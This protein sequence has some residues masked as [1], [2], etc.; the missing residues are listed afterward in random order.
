MDIAQDFDQRLERLTKTGSVETIGR[1]RQNVQPILG[2]RRRFRG[3]DRLELSAKRIQRLACIGQ[4]FR[5][6][7][8]RFL[9]I[10][11]RRGGLQPQDIV[12]E[13]LG[14]D[15]LIVQIVQRIG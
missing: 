3:I 6:G 14:F 9:G 8:G 12:D 7:R 2:N 5:L 15:L 13:F 1:V 11:G 10:F 4:R